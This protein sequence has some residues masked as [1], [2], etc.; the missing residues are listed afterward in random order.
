[1]GS[2]IYRPIANYAANSVGV[3]LTDSRQCCNCKKRS[4]GAHATPS[5]TKKHYFNFPLREEFATGGGGANEEFCATRTII[6]LLLLCLTLFFHPLLKR[7]AEALLERSNKCRNAQCIKLQVVEL[8]SGKLLL[9]CRTNSRHGRRHGLLRY[10]G[11]Y[12]RPRVLSLAAKLWRR[13]LS[14]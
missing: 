5:G 10:I 9:K 14:Y 13:D 12:G 1:M 8:R 3:T 4:G 7:S 11:L 6:Q 2:P